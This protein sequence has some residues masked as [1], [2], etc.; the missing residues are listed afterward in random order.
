[1]ELRHL[2][3]Q[4]TRDEFTGKLCGEILNYLFGGCPVIEIGGF[5]IVAITGF[6]REA[7]LVEIERYS[8]K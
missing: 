1:M 8:Y 2:T 7:R 4:E 6:G 3:E 5:G